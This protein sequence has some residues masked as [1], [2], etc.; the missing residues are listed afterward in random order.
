MRYAPKDEPDATSEFESWE[1]VLV[2]SQV[3]DFVA[4]QT[5]PPD[6][7]PQDL[8]QECLAHWWS[9]RARYDERRAASRETFL[10]K[11]VRGKLQDLARGWRAEKRGSGRAAISLDAPVSRDDPDGP[12][13]GAFLPSGKDVEMD[14]AAAAGLKMI[15][16]RLSSRQRRIIAG[17]LDGMT[18]SGLSKRLDI[19][20]DTL[21]RELKRIQHIFREEE[22]AEYLE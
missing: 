8:Y 3:K 6:L 19:S 10:R 5:L 12:T 20:R 11:V 7:E 14:A 15:T 17:V 2:R 13:L 16:A 22:L 9:Q 21:H 4:R 18:K 1:I